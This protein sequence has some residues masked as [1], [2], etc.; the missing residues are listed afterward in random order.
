MRCMDGPV[1]IALDG[2]EFNCP[3]WSQRKRGKE[4]IDYFR[5]LFAATTLAA[6]GEAQH[7]ASN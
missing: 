5:T 6:G 3:N 4:N 7:V 1:R 2:T